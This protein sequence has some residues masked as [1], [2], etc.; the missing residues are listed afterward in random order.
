MRLYYGIIC[1]II[2]ALLLILS[3][4]CGWVDYNWIQFLAALIIVA[5]IVTHIYVNYKKPAY[6]AEDEG[7]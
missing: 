3:Y 7:K 6:S 4:L 5:G 2:G 1:A